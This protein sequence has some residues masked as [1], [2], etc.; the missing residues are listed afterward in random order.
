[1]TEQA[2]QVQRPTVVHFP[3]L[4]CPTCKRPADQVVK[5]ADGSYVDAC[6]EH[7]TELASGPLP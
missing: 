7:S 5:T 1:M 3:T 4:R 2:T 6:L